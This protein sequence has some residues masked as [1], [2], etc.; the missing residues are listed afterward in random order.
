MAVRHWFKVC[1]LIYLG[2]RL[3]WLSSSGLEKHVGDMLPLRVFGKLVTLKVLGGD[4]CF[5]TYPKP[6]RYQL[7]WR[8]C[9]LTELLCGLL[10]CLLFLHPACGNSV[11]IPRFELQD[12]KLLFRPQ[13]RFVFKE[14]LARKFPWTLRHRKGIFLG[15]VD[16]GFSDALGFTWSGWGHESVVMLGSPA[17]FV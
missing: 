13:C 15:L 11:P 8:N 6:P 10:P 14:S 2:W 4:L 12:L 17:C 16:S 1:S 3:F 9:E 5:R 7:L